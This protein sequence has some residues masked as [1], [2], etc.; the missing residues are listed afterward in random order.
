MLLLFVRV[1]GG[2]SVAFFVCDGSGEDSNGNNNQNDVDGQ[3]AQRRGEER[4]CMRIEGRGMRKE[5]VDNDCNGDD[6]QRD[7][8]GNV[9]RSIR[10]GGGDV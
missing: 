1:G 2:H 6:G 5:N 9:R 3:R 8:D 7:S 10:G 4:C